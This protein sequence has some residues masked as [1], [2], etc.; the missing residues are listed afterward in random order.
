ME[1][2]TSRTCEPERSFPRKR[3]FGGAVRNV[4][5]AE[6]IGFI[7]VKNVGSVFA[8]LASFVLMKARFL[9]RART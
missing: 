5:S 2:G 7:L 1:T 8:L 4:T 9:R 6:V 3:G